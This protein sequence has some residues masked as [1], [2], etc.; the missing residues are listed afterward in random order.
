MNKEFKDW[1]KRIR[2]KWFDP[3][4]NVDPWFNG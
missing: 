1:F 2:T 3:D 4:Q